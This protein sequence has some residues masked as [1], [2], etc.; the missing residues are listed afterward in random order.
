MSIATDGNGWRTDP[1]MCHLG[2][3]THMTPPRSRAAML[4]NRGR[5]QATRRELPH[6]TP[7]PMNLDGKGPRSDALI[8]LLPVR[9][10]PSARCRQR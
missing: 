8:K 1:V 5:T 2:W 7:R 10:E 6:S 4:G 3:R 9:R